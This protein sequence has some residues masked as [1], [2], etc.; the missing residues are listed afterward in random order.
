MHT[1]RW[2][3]GSQAVLAVVQS[4]RHALDSEYASSL[5]LLAVLSAT[6]WLWCYA[7]YL[8]QTRKDR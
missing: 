3:M 6:L 4:A 2:L 7:E 5:I 1:L 8:L